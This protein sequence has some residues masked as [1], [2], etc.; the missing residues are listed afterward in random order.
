M[1]YTLTIEPVEG[2]TYQYGFH[3]GTDIDLARSLIEEKFNAANTHPNGSRVR[4]MALWQ[5]GRI[6]D[7]YDGQWSSQYDP[8]WED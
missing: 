7:V 6:V 2:K 3:L 8:C 5:G 4:T 1:T